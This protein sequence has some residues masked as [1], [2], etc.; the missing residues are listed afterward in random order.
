MSDES[1]LPKWAR[2]ELANL[3]GRIESLEAARKEIVQPWREAAPILV[4]LQ[5]IDG[6]AIE[7]GDES[8]SFM[9]DERMGN[10]RGRVSVLRRSDYWGRYLRIMGN[11]SIRISPES[12]NVVRVSLIDSDDFDKQEARNA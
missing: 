3:R 2:S 11:D 4:G 7:S 10:A 6:Y 12:S 1:K 9:V 8:V 5:Q